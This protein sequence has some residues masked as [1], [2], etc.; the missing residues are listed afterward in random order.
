M[1]AEADS[2]QTLRR[3]KWWQNKS[4]EWVYFDCEA[5]VGE[6]EMDCSLSGY[7]RLKSGMPVPQ[8]MSK[9]IPVVT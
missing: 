3:A 6:Q 7:C 9:V 4:K 8:G 1:E 5:G 2:S